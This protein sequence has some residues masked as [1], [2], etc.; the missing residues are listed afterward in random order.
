MEN[1]V[2]TGINIHDT[3]CLDCE[4]LMFYEGYER[5]DELGKMIH[6]EI[7]NGLEM[8]FLNFQCPDCKKRASIMI[9]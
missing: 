9:Q 2:W 4:S 1:S 6:S 8:V 7:K 5:G 3:F